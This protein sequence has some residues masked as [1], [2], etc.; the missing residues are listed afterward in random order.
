MPAHADVTSALEQ[1]LLAQFG[2]RLKGARLSRGLSAAALAQ[3]VGISRTTLHAVEA[4]DPSPTIGTYLRVMSALGAAGDFALLATRV[5]VPEE[6]SDERARRPAA[7]IGSDRHA[8]QDLQS[9]M[10]HREAV[11]LIQQHPSLIKKATDTLERWRTRGDEHTRPLWD[12]WA[13]I[14]QRRE[15]RKALANTQRGRQLRQ[16]SPLSVLLPQETRLRIIGEVR[17]LQRAGSG[18]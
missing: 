5:S 4:G 13:G 14:L 15:W 6:H 11:K 8:A 3:Q 12:E 1:Q 17:S 9:L 16:A 2:E 7:G 10:L 18:A